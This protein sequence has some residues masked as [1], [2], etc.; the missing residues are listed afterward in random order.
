MEELI[1]LIEE[2][3]SRFLDE[4]T[5]SK[6]DRRKI[7]RDE[8]FTLFDFQKDYAKHVDKAL[9]QEDIQQAKRIFDKLHAD[10]QQLPNIHA[11][12]RK[13]FRILEELHVKLTKYLE[14]RKENQQMAAMLA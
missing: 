3:I 6:I 8:E 14:E 4:R 2:D 9:E 13:V 7:I 1:K 12:K 11:D 5:D 10:Y